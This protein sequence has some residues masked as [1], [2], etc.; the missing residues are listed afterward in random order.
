MKNHKIILFFLIISTSICIS[1]PINEKKS[2]LLSIGSNAKDINFMATKYISN[3]IAL[4]LALQGYI[5]F[6]SD[7]K[8][9]AYNSNLIQTTDY[10]F[11]I[12]I[13]I[14]K[15]IK[16]DVE[17]LECYY[18]FDAKGYYT[19]YFNKVSLRQDFDY[20][21]LIPDMRQTDY[22]PV[23]MGL[24]LSPLF[25]TRYYLGSKIAFGAE[26][27]LNMLNIGHT[28]GERSFFELIKYYKGEPYSNSINIQFYNSTIFEFNIAPQVMIS[29]TIKLK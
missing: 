14:Q 16:I 12:A 8:N 22:R 27:S 23:Q 11:K 5:N 4:R 24:I 25:G 21:S 19:K 10:D 2:F 6:R 7:K 9:S 17:K 26:L 1:Q 28:I 15:T 18:G 20:L 13:G 29:A 3:K